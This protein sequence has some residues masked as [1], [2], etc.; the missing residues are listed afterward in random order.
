MSLVL[1]GKCEKYEVIT[2]LLCGQV[3]RE[4]NLGSSSISIPFMIIPMVKIVAPIYQICFKKVAIT[5]LLYQ[6]LV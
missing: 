5:H 3:R 2:F 1:A 6:K 4:N